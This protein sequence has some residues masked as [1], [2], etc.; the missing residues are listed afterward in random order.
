[1]K[2]LLRF[3]HLNRFSTYQSISY[4]LLIRGIYLFYGYKKL[5]AEQEN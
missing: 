1:M 4:L 5:S 3:Q 2:N